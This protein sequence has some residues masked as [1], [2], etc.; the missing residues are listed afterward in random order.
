MDD[1]GL[2]KYLQDT[3]GTTVDNKA[4]FRLTWTTGI[5]E[6]RH[7]IFEDYYGE[8]FLR[9]VKETRE[10]LKYPY[11]QDR[12]VLEKIKLID[13][14]SRALGLLDPNPYIYDAIYTFQD[15]QGNFLPLNREMLDAAMMLFFQFYTRMT[16]K[17]RLDFRITEL[18][19][20]DLERKGKVRNLLGGGRAAHGF[21]LERAAGI[22]RRR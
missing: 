21:V 11:A 20:K 18:A 9:E 22:D 8:I 16:P 4:L 2:N 15:K 6:F 10:V 5:T 17:E 13:G 14:N 12:W 7:S 3:Y 19:R 1:L